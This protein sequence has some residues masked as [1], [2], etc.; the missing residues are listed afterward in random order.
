MGISLSHARY[1]KIKQIIVDLFV[2]YDI[3]CI[4]VSA[5]EGDFKGKKVIP[6]STQGSNP[7]TFLKDFTANAQN[8]QVGIMP[9]LTTWARNITKPCIIKSC[10]G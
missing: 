3:R 2:P 7:G 1:E 4:P 8:A 6:F 10:I 9:V 5:F